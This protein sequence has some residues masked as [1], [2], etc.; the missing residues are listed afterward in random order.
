MFWTHHV[1]P[2][3]DIYFT[4]FIRPCYKYCF[5]FAFVYR[6]ACMRVFMTVYAPGPL[7]FGPTCAMPSNR[8]RL[9]GA[10]PSRIF[11]SPATSFVRFTVAFRALHGSLARDIIYTRAYLRG[12]RTRAVRRTLCWP[13]AVNAL[14]CSPYRDR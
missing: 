5:L 11:L 12:Y 2:A 10:G 13:C 7:P 4:I 9:L 14:K 6:P 1:F 8:R 3:I